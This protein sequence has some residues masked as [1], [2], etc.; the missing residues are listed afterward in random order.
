[1]A[2][3]SDRPMSTTVEVLLQNPA[4]AQAW[5]AFVARYGPRIHGWCGHWGV[6]GADAEDVT[7]EVLTSLARSLDTFDPAKGSFRAWLKTV[8]HNAWRSFTRRQVR[9]GR[10]SGDSAVLEQLHG[11]PAR[12]DLVQELQ[13][14][15]DLELFEQAMGLVRLRT[16]PR[17]WAVFEAMALQ[18]RTGADTAAQLGIE[19]AEAFRIK[20]KVQ[21]AVKEEVE[22]GRGP[23]N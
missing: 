3:P 21:R 10:G 5:D 14:E 13:Q 2:E 6:R 22:R 1:M 4:S 8:T 23:E 15:F 9:P 19:T 18:G 17:D 11:L 12:D 7:Q 20:Y 16:P